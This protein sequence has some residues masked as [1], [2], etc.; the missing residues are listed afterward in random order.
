MV[1]ALPAVSATESQ[2]YAS[3]EVLHVLSKL[4]P[5]PK[6]VEEAKREAEQVA[7]AALQ[8]P[9]ALVL[10]VDLA[11]A[12]VT[13]WKRKLQRRSQKSFRLMMAEK[14]QLW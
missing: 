14:R 1:R 12:F 13:A 3:V 4:P 9:L 6:Q 11:L 5:L 8:A 7:L 2:V 10:S